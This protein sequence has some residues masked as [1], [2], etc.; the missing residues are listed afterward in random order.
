[1]GEPRYLLDASVFVEAARRYYAFDIAPRFWER[2][3]EHASSGAVGSIE[4]V[5]EELDRGKDAVAAWAKDKFSDAFSPTDDGDV[6]ACYRRVMNWVQNQTQ[7]TD[8][9]KAEFADVADGWLVAL[10]V[11][12]PC[13]VVTQEVLASSARRRVPLPNVCVGF[14]VR[15]IDTFAML[16]ELGVQL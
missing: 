14:N 7:F 1:M 6:L 4:R 8:A 11:V 3:I 2:L 5:R 9:A 16:R 10:A 13:I 15:Y 12:K